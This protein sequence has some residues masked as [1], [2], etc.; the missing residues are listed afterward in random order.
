MSRFLIDT[1][2]MIALIATWHDGHAAAVSEWRRRT[3]KGEQPVLAV[4]CWSEAY[5]VLTRLPPPHR[6]H[7]AVVWKAVQANWGVCPTVALTARE[8]LQTLEACAQ[9]D[10]AGGRVYDE[11]IAACA[12]KAGV[13]V[14]VTCNPRHFLRHS[15]RLEIRA[16]QA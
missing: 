1:N 5:S 12:L 16:P 2:C 13:E 9:A 11:L 8:W 14:L 10:I 4:P 6:L 3:E 7:P 15:D